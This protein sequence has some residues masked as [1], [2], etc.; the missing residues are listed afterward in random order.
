MERDLSDCHLLAYTSLSLLLCKTS[1]QKGKTWE[2]IRETTAASDPT[3]SHES[4]GLD[5]SRMSLHPHTPSSG[6]VF[7]SLEVQGF[8][9]SLLCLTVTTS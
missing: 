1:G 8:V 2:S 7:L 4:P 3:Q 9:V 5:N 6:R